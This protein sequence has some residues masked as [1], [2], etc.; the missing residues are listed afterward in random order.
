MGVYATT[1]TILQNYPGLPQSDSSV[2]TIL[3]NHIVNAEGIVHGKVAR[4]Y[5]IPFSSTPPIIKTIS[6][7]LSVFYYM[8]ASYMR[9]GQNVSEWVQ[10]LYDNA[11]AQ[12]DEIQDRKIDLT[13]AS[14]NLISERS[15]KKR[16]SSTTENYTPTFDLDTITSADIDPDRLADVADARL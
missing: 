8:R 2:T 12:L 3:T 16:I 13:D 9:D 10:D 7:D 11:I 14:N 4:R 15:T 1:T 5:D 6:E